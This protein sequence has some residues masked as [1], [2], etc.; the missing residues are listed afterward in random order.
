[1][2][3]VRGS[4]NLDQAGGPYVVGIGIFDGVHL[5]HQALIRK[6]LALS[7][8][9]G[10][11]SLA[12][13]LDP[14]PMQVLRPANA[15]KLIEPL[16][17]RLAHL[18]TLGIGTTVIEP[19]S[20]EFAA[21]SAESFAHEILAER[22]GARHIVVGS[23]FTF[24]HQRGGNVQKLAEWGQEIGF[25][26]HPVETLRINTITVSSSKIREYIWAGTM[27]G[28]ALLLGRPFALSGVILRGAQRGTSL[29]FPTANLHTH[30]ELIPSNG[31][32]VGCTTGEAGSFAAVINV[33][34]TPTFG[35]KELKIE[36]HLPDYHG[37]P[38]Y[39]AAMTIEFIDRLRDEMRFSDIEALKAQIR[40]DIDQARHILAEAPKPETHNLQPTGVVRP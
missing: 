3:V 38:L 28:A 6:V 34:Y 26:V 13:T 10:L 2:R 19:F 29:G 22:V 35:G 21:R 15:P 9:T 1:M 14:H 12:Y 20:T 24:G 23:Q 16:G 33:G 40:R 39:G 8:A 30:F 17:V 37:G 32:Y 7:S 25:G 4:A 11:S 5:G 36:A 31:V 18:E 27:R